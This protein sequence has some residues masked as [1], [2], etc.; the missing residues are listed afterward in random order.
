MSSREL[1][2]NPIMPMQWAL[3]LP[4]PLVSMA[5]KSVSVL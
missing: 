5:L 3:S 4:R 1:A 2:L